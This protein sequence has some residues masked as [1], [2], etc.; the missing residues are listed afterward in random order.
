MRPELAQ[1]AELLQRNTPEA[2]EEAIS[3]LQS[4]VYSFSMKVCG[5]LLKHWKEH[6]WYPLH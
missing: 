2:V 3:L 6:R 5:H 1:A 4:T